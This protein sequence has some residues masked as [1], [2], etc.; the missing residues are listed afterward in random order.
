[1][2]VGAMIR[3]AWAAPLV[4]ALTLTACAVQPDEIN[5]RDSFAEQ[6]AS[7][8]EVADFERDGEELTFSGPDGRGGTADWRVRIDSAVLEPG[9]DDQVPYEGHIVSSWYRDGELIES[10]GT[11]SGLP[12]VIQ[13]AG[14]AQVC[15][16]LWDTASNAWDW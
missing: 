1:M 3:R 11:M 10:L 8:A 14:I 9:P 7:V 16:A 4:G 15:Y 13:D 12:T 2:E 5:L 6:I